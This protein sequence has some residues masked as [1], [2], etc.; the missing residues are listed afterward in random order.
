MYDLYKA[1]K[2]DPGIIIKDIIHT[3]EEYM[4]KNTG[5]IP[6]KAIFQKNLNDKM[7]DEEFLGDTSS[8]LRP[9]EIYEPLEAFNS[10]TKTLVSD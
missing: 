3:Y 8:L 7:E 2:L 9:D 5:S 4:N 6:A 1:L 10:I